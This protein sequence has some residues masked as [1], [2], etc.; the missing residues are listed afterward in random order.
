ML[1][2]QEIL[3]GGVHWRWLEGGQGEPL[4]LFAGFGDS[5]KTFV[6]LARQLTNQYQVFL[7]E[8]PGFDD[9]PDLAPEDCGLSAQVERM[10]R[11]M[12][13]LGIKNPIL[14]GNS[15]G[16]Q[17]AVLLG[18]KTKPKALILL[19]PQGMAS[20]DFTPYS[21]K[22]NCPQ[23]EDDFAQ[24]LA[25]LYHQPPQLASDQMAYLL[26][27]Q[28]ARW[29][30]LNQIRAQIRTEP[31]HQLNDQLTGLDC[32][33]LLIWGRSDQRIPPSLAQY[34]LKA[35]P[36]VTYHLLEAC[37]HLPQI[38]QTQLTSQL[39]LSFLNPK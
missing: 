29:E 18:L 16:G 9:D 10:G 15:S 27:R 2:K 28:Q 39:I 30:R 6:R 36:Q 13:S 7:P 21:H 11:W 37:G 14:G 26:T 31:L 19:A 20:P 1:E 17:L 38:E 12:E 25:Q 33:T 24:I 35:L 4:I 23:T 5:N 3:L 8:T 22:P 32:P 34:W